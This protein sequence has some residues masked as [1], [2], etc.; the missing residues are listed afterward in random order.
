MKIQIPYGDNQFSIKIPDNNLAGIIRP[1]DSGMSR[2][3]EVD[4]S[5]FQDFIQNEDPLLFIVNDGSRPTPTAKILEQLHPLLINKE[6]TFII[7][8]GSHR[9]P[10]ETELDFIFG[11]LLS[12]YQNQIMV[13]DAYNDASLRFYGK[14]S[15]GTPVYLNQVLGSFSKIVVIG[16]VEPH[17]FAGFTGGRKAILPGISGYQTIE[18]NHKLAMCSGSEPLKLKGNPVHEDQTEALKYLEEKKILSI[19]TVLDADDQ[20]LSV[21]CGDLES[22]LYKAVADCNACY[23][24]PVSQKADIVVTIAVPPLDATLYQAHKAI[25]NVRS[26]LKENGKLI[27][28]APCQEGL[29]NDTFIRLLQSFEDPQNVIEHVRNE[30]K[31][32]YHK[33]ARLAELALSCQLLILSQL[34]DDMIESIFFNP[35]A[36]LQKWIVNEINHDPDIQI[37][38]VDKASV[39]VPVICD[40]KC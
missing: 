4:I 31:L 25:E 21:K 27:L 5:D 23:S 10:T 2:N 35:V 3:T 22:S 8:T 34:D 11:S 9:A 16:S 17:Y 36:D 24:V 33:A 14:T 28:I 18:Q 26:I 7:A 12:H 37:A 13:H 39:V 6:V 30:Y 20:I 19:M 1:E 40:E 15:R 32:G 38:I 29:G